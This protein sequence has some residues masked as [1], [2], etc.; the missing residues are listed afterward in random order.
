M[1]VRRSYE[2]FSLIIRINYCYSVPRFYSIRDKKV[3]YNSLVLPGLLIEI[4][5]GDAK[6]DT[7]LPSF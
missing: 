6:T 3:H 7:G 1:L 2:L 4:L 5:P